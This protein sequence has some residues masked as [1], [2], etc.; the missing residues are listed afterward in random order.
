MMNRIVITIVASS[1]VASSLPLQETGIYV[2]NA[3]E[4]NT[5][6]EQEVLL[7]NNLLE[8]ENVSEVI[9]T[10]T[11]KTSESVTKTSLVTTTYETTTNIQQ[12]D[13]ASTL[14]TEVTQPTTQETEETLPT[15]IIQGEW[16]DNIS[17]KL[18]KD[19]GNLV[20]SGTGE[21]EK[22]TNYY[23]QMPFYNYREYVRTV[24]FEEGITSLC[25]YA[26]Y[27]CDQVTEI[28]LPDSLTFIDESAFEKCSKLQSISI[29]DAVTAIEA[30]AFYNCTS[31]EEIKLPNSL[32][33]IGNYAFYG[34]ES[35]KKA[36]IPDSIETIGNDAFNKCS[37]LVC[38]INSSNLISI[39]SYAFYKCEQL[40][41][42][43]L[44]SKFTSLGKEAFNGCSSLE[45]VEFSELMEEIP[46]SA[47][48]NC[49]SLKMVTIPGNIQSIGSYAFYNCTSLE[50]VVVEQGVVSI[51][52]Y[53]F[54]KCTSLSD[55]QLA[56]SATELGVKVFENTKY[57]DSLEGEFV[58]LSNGTLY[59]YNGE[60]KNITIP[61]NVITIASG[62]FKDKEIESVVFPD[63]VN[64]I[65]GAFDGCTTLKKVK[66][67]SD[68]KVINENAFSGCTSLD[69]VEFP[70]KLE[71]IDTAAF[72]NCSALSNISF[73]ES[74]TSIE[75]SAF[76]KCIALESIAL[77][78]S[79]LNI[80]ESAF[81][82]CSLLADVDIPDNLEV[83]G[84]NAFG[85]T[86]FLLSKS[87]DLIIFGKSLYYCNS[88]ATEIS[89]PEGIHSITDD[90]FAF[91][92]DLE[93]VTL[94]STLEK[95][96]SDAFLGCHTMKYIIIPDSVTQIGSRAIGFY[97][98]NGMSGF[99]E[100]QSAMV[101]YGSKDSVAQEY[102]EENEIKFYP[103]L[104]GESC[105]ENVTW[106]LDVEEGILT[107]SGTGDMTNYSV[108]SS[109][110]SDNNPSP[111][112][113][114][115]SLIK[116]VVIGEGIT[117]IGAYAFDECTDLSEI[118]LPSTLIQINK[119]AFSD[120]TALRKVI[121]P[122]GITL[123]D[124]NAFSNT[125]IN[126]INLPESIDTIGSYCF[127][128]CANLESLVI[129]SNVTEF[130]SDIFNNSPNLEAVHISSQNKEYISIDGVIYNSSKTSMIYYPPGKKDIVWEAPDGLTNI[131]SVNS[132]YLKTI[133][134]PETIQKL[135]G[136]TFNNCTNLNR[137]IFLG[138]APVPSSW[139][140]SSKYTDLH[141]KG[142]VIVSCYFSRDGWDEL[143][144]STSDKELITWDDLD[145][146]SAQ[147]TL[148]IVAESDELEEGK[149]MILQPVINP[150]LAVMF[151]WKSSNNKIITVSNDGT[152]T[153]IK[154]GMAVVT[155][156]SADGEYS[157]EIEITVTPKMEVGAGVEIYETV[158]LD[159]E[160]VGSP[161]ISMQF[162]CEALQGIYF[163]N[164]S[165]LYF[166]SI[167]THTYKLVYNYQN[168]VGAY[169]EN[170]M[171][172]TVNT[173]GIQIYD[174]E[175]QTLSKNIAIPSGYT[176]TAV[177]ADV[178]GRIYVSAYESSNKINNRVFL[179]S[180]EGE[181]ISQT[182]FP[183][184]VFCFDGFDQSNGRF[185]VESYYDYYS[186]GYHHP[187][188]GLNVGYVDAR[189][190]ISS[191]RVTS[192]MLEQGLIS[193]SFDCLS[194]L[195]QDVYY[196]HQNGAALFG[197]KYLVYVSSLT[198]TLTV[199]DSDSDD[200]SEKMQIS[201]DVEEYE[202]SST[203][204]DITAVGTRTVYHSPHNTLI[205][206]ENGKILKEY[207]PETMK[208]ISSNEISD[209]AYSL[210]NW[211][212]GVYVLER[213]EDGRYYLEYLDWSDPE[214]IAIK[215]ETETMNVGNTQKL[216]LENGK[217]RETYY[218][219]T[220]SDENVLTVTSTG[221]V[222][223]WN[224]GE[225]T[226]YCEYGNLCA[227]F[228]IT[229]SPSE[230][231]KTKTYTSASGYIS[232]NVSDN[233]YSVWDDTIKSYLVES[234]TQEMTRVEY[235][236]EEKGVL[237]ETY[238]TNDYSLKDT[239]YIEAELPIFGGFYSGSQY[240][241]M[242]FGQ[243]NM[244]EDDDAEV[245]RVVRYT[246]D[247][248]RVD[249][250]SIYGANTTVPF[251]AGNL[252]IDENNGRLFVYTSHKMYADE[253]EINHQANLIFVIGID[254]MLCEDSFYD[255]YNQSNGYVSHSFTQFIK[256][257]DN[258][259]YRV[260]HGD[261]EPRGISLTK[262]KI[263]E[264]IV[265][266]S[267]AINAYKIKGG[268]G[269]NTTG[270][271]IGGFELSENNCLI[272]FDSVD[273][274]AESYNLKGKR[275]IFLYVVDKSISNS[276]TIPITN[277]DDKSSITVSTPQL[278]KLNQDA[279]L[280]MWEERDSTTNRTVTRLVSLNGEGKLT[281]EV[282]TAH[283]RLS[284]CQPIFMNDGILRWYVTNGTKMYFYSINP[285]DLNSIQGN[286]ITWSFDDVNCILTIK[287][288]GDMEDYE[289]GNSTPWANIIKNV[290]T[291]V[292]E[293]GVTSI[294]NNSFAGAMSLKFVTIPNTVTTIGENA[295]VDCLRLTKLYVPSCVNDIQTN[296]L[297]YISS[298]KK[299]EDFTIVGEEGSEAEVYALD[300]GIKFS[301]GVRVNGD[302]NDDGEVDLKDVVL[303]RRYIVG[304]WDVD[305]DVEIADVNNDKE[306]DLKDVVLIRRYVAGGWDVELM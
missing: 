116:S 275:N 243:S 39:G 191:M 268:N 238:L 215:G 247:W 43:T 199:A 123:L 73:P 58:V 201:R 241:F 177:G 30:D 189:G 64:N 71:K 16:G 157:S 127:S 262:A 50:K 13:V 28:S 172:Y 60:G 55:V 197:D 81:Q 136:Y 76:S 45:R 240:Y 70:E 150:V 109:W 250:C 203:Y 93:K 248:K 256:T 218:T 21:M 102:A 31:L 101:I 90:A 82:D 147:N 106:S 224:A 8:E 210:I 239:R 279:F 15:N 41:S 214:S 33:K 113:Q 80:G 118:T 154:P 291:I 219:W 72:K 59:Q 168:L 298:G 145:N 169:S 221:L 234:A 91:C 146:V 121:L 89:I 4:V 235:I 183:T 160:M 131:N 213:T 164:N 75:A 232:N 63:G 285:F 139:S 245:V 69:T 88:N 267:A 163:L 78:E 35:L 56:D 54:C 98:N 217:D 273:M 120:C 112:N 47:F 144:E 125:G 40:K 141:F 3:Y 20:V 293:E 174:M 32:I 186:W 5:T 230:T 117:S 165:K 193:R 97:C 36:D 140:S 103:L 288:T 34:C 124:S 17:Y 49:T 111:F 303:I 156:S 110:S 198:N 77:P 53:V 294:G 151:T 227:E 83:V 287:G 253:D 19:T 242:V 278:V 226:V 132:P 161:F 195:C 95:I 61:S 204:T 289:Q 261:S 190:H 1:V 158:E 12:Q 236:G 187:G 222:T 271:S 37:N 229:V 173:S 67:P 300:N 155:C 6:N 128:N 79:L 259:V 119:G 211:K 68:M 152:I 149:N 24:V 129:P 130:S 277:Y 272:A 237:I 263:N 304:D 135:N 7:I 180:S 167:V 134:I 216:T 223:A 265:E 87:D 22:S 153:A 9:T 208:V 11:K 18:N 251:D 38:E 162:P 246:K 178:Q 281:S 306:V 166:Y 200:F 282:E 274:T 26:L 185:Y 126:E 296:A 255:V 52:D 249:A 44:S 23:S 257:D 148:K 46:S 107:I 62:T 207:D 143:M 99:Y 138:D 133:V 269:N 209:Y 284:D 10:T 182:S 276:K 142:N 212:D 220:S 137:I 100:K 27:G 266:L 96:G 233:Q 228:K 85:N 122:D 25:N 42:V 74:L 205:V 297:G 295:M 175:A 170:S 188:R 92:M 66:L 194:Y 290:K 280:L 283:I 108:Y 86:A 115:R 48:R 258:F 57:G 171:I 51:G 104:N 244:S 302:V 260:D 202:L 84:A 292:V 181:M 179:L 264:S 270:V 225:A 184:K 192:G 2:A 159:K 206:Y 231:K 94:P 14:E 176:A 254:K 286:E 299:L 114:Y 65:S 105:G 252:R 29:P 196:E 301:N 305:L